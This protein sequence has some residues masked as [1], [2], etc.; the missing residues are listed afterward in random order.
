MLPGVRQR[1][2]QRLCR[3]LLFSTSPNALQPPGHQVSGGWLYRIVELDPIL[4]LPRPRFGDESFTA[5]VIDRRLIVRTGAI[6]D[7][8]LQLAARELCRV[9]SRRKLRR[10][11]GP[12]PFRPRATACGFFLAI[13]A[14]RR[15]RPWWSALARPRHA[16]GAPRGA[17]I[18]PRGYCVRS[19][20]SCPRPKCSREG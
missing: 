19:L 20:R 6:A 18:S 16:R 12:P 17:R 5:T 7:L 10:C 4:K 9:S 2:V 11:A 1:I 15:I 14:R 13:S 8:K 3:R